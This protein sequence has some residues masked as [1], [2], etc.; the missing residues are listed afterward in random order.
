[1]LTRNKLLGLIGLV[2]SAFVGGAIL[3]SV[4]RLG[5]TMVHPFLLNWFRITIALL[6]LLLL[7]RNKFKLSRVLQKQ[8][9]LPALLLAT[10]LGLNVIMFAFGVTRTTLVASQL[11]YVLT[12]LATGLLAY[13]FLGEKINPKKAFG[14]TLA[15]A[16]VLL[17]II[18]SN[19]AKQRLALG[20]FYGNFLIF[21]GMFGYSSYLIFSKKLSP[22]F[23]ILEMVMITNLFLSVLLLP[24][25]VYGLYLQ[26]LAQINWSSM[27][28][29]TTIAVSALVFMALS[30]LSLKH[31]S[32]NTV[33]LA[34]L[35]SPEFAAL[36]GIMFYDEKLS[37]ILLLSMALSIGGTAI[38]VSAEKF[39][40]I[41]K[42]KLAT[43]KIRGLLK[44]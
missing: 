18:F 24:F 30:Q 23:S 39:S 10:G 2:S 42:M 25:A 19:S 12:P 5:A 27:L 21:I 37:L 32:A 3:P 43:Q 14:M 33:S 6:I 7:F 34:S 4:I 9:F 38:S 28:A 29:M 15:F 1:M 44:R 26:G 22:S 35:L 31:L 17:L 11:I 20:T 16:G 13:L 8:H 41:D 40:F 36:T